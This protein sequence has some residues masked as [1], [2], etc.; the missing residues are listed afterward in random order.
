MKFSINDFKAVS[1]EKYH[2][3]P[4]VHTTLTAPSFVICSFVPRPLE[5]IS[6]LR[7]PFYHSNIEFDEVIFYHDGEFLVDMV[8]IKQV[9]PTTPEELN[10]DLSLKHL[11]KYKKIQILKE[12]MRKQ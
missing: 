5:D 8:L 2:L 9:L 7:I 4:S 6:V 10:M 11:K 1:S 3:P 12:L